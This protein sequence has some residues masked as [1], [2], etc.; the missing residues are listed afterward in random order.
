MISPT[1]RG[2]ILIIG[3]SCSLLL[4]LIYP[5]FSLCVLTSLLWGTIVSSFAFVVFSSLGFKLKRGYSRNSSMG[6]PVSLPVI[7][8]NSSGFTRERIVI[9]E[10]LPFADS[11]ISASA[12]PPFSP[13]E[14]K[15]AMREAMAIRRGIFSLG[16]VRLCG[17]DPACIFKFTRKFFL[18]GEI[19]IF[20]ETVELKSM[21][22]GLR[23]HSEQSLTGRPAGTAGYG[24]EYFG[25]KEFRPGDDMRH[26]HWKA[27]AKQGKMI[28]Q[29]FEAQTSNQINIVLDTSA[30]SV[31][32]NHPQSNFECLIR[33]ASS[34]NAYFHRR[35]YNI[36]FLSSSGEDRNFTMI[37]GT[38]YG[39][40]DSINIFLAGA[41]PSKTALRALVDEGLEV[42]PQNS[43][44]YLLTMS[45]DAAL[46]DKFEQ[47]FARRIDIRWIYAPEKN[48]PKTKTVKAAPI[49]APDV[50]S[51]LKPITIG[52]E[53]DIA[54][55]LTYG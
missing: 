47:L 39:V 34:L 6:E 33:I 26:I 54:T 12:V 46:N 23:R 2:F 21:P 1:G 7:V 52:A 18:P 17:G 44:L 19:V 25:I 4:L 32:D 45:A 35:P 16:A 8:T 3:A 51:A 20:P 41:S 14:T 42:F 40:Y 50:P 38:S 55:I 53:S 29:E 9:K 10:N 36:C 37:N 30:A 5:N 27:S 11:R 13:R 43:I 24:Y 48:F 49:Q 28:V 31:G 15:I 22:L